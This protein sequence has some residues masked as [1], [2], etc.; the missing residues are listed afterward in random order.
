MRI[1]AVPVVLLALT[2]ALGLTSCSDDNTDKDA[3]PATSEAAPTTAEDE[4]EASRS[5]A[6][7]C[8]IEV[9]IDGLLGPAFGS[10]DPDAIVAASIEAEPLL[11]EA[12]AAAPDEIAD[13][14]DTL[15]AA[16]RAA[17]DGD[18]SALQTPGVGQ[19]S[20]QV[21]TFCG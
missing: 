21:D 5:P 8:A 1:T 4:T 19:A 6:T 12:A 7:Y 3:A 20:E 17:A 14:V 2:T 16:V 13:E 10:G 15:I 9:Q 18:P 11:V